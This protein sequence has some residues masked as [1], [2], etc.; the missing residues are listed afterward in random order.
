MAVEGDPPPDLLGTGSFAECQRRCSTSDPE[1]ASCAAGLAPREV[2]LRGR[3]RRA[4]R[5]PA[6]SGDPASAVGG[7]SH[8]LAFSFIW[9]T[10]HKDLIWYG[11]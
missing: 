10:I 6:H 2:Q 3:H 1:P 11:P 4:H 8:H 5:P 7:I 9:D